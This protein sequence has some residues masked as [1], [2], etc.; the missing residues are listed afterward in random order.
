MLLSSQTFNGLIFPNKI[1][2]L[3]EDN[4]KVAGR[5]FA[6]LSRKVLYLHSANYIKPWYAPRSISSWISRKSGCKHDLKQSRQV[7]SY[8]AIWP[9]AGCWSSDRR[10]TRH[11][12]VNRRRR[13]STTV[14]RYNLCVAPPPA[15]EKLHQLPAP[16]P[17]PRTPSSELCVFSEPVE[18]GCSNPLS[19]R[20]S[21]IKTV[22][23]SDSAYPLIREITSN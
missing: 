18:I 3:T 13:L 5:K 1:Y 15:A 10:K 12:C 16:V 9:Y 17:V 14:F 23:R 4:F 11:L 20:V 6:L 22:G 21:K 2:S 7:C 19:R 8:D